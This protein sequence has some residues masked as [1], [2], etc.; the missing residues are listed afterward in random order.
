M[1]TGNNRFQAASNTLN[2]LLERPKKSICPIFRENGNKAEQFGSGVL[3]NISGEI[4]ILTAAHVLDESD[5]CDLLIPGKKSLIFPSGFFVRGPNPISGKR[6]DDHIDLAYI[7]LSK[8][9][10]DDL[11]DDLIP[12]NNKDF[13]CSD[14]SNEGDAYSLIGYPA[15]KSSSTNTI[16]T[17]ELFVLTGEGQKNHF[18]ENLGLNIKDN[19]IIRF[20]R[21]KGFCLQREQRVL[22]PNP[23]GLSGGG[24]FSWSKDLPNKNEL[25]TPKLAGIITEYH[26]N[27]HFF[28]STRLELFIKCICY[29]Y[30]SLFSAKL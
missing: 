5:S 8:E 26:R 18:Y 6:I 24:V 27:K 17:T 14:V 16:S 7:H 23:Q 29:R 19:L 12:L 15:S 25:K 9:I 13:D 10:A 11:N 22:M 2:I 4:F 21:K 30:P 3:I 1:Q 20:R 28:V